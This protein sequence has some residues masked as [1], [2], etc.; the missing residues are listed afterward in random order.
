[1]VA[2]R[3]LAG[4]GRRRWKE[5]VALIAAVFFDLGGTLFEHLPPR[6]TLDNLAWALETQGVSVGA[7]AELE[8]YLTLRAQLEQDF[9]GRAFFLHRDLVLE[10]AR[11]FARTLPQAGLDEERFARS[12]YALQRSAVTEHL[13]PRE[14]AAHVLQTLRSWGYYVAIV[15]NIDEDYLGPLLA[16]V[17]DFAAVDLV[18]SSEVCRSCKPDPVIFRRALERSGFDASEVLYVG[19]SR[20]NDVFG[21]GRQGFR[22]AGRAGD[23]APA[24]VQAGAT[25]AGVELGGQPVQDRFA[26]A[27]PSDPTVPDLLLKDLAELLSVLTPSEAG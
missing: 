20:T 12:F 7:T 3:G 14:V 26:K 8:P 9:A 15:S 19:D 2:T 23:Q 27:R 25:A 4:P 1:M 24:V 18:L 10:A 21:A 16:R 5:W 17:P 13:R 11:S 22:T 6:A